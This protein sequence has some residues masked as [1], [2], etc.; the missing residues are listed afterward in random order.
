MNIIEKFKVIE[1]GGF[2][3]IA[4]MSNQT[5]KYCIEPL[6][7][8]NYNNWKFRM[9]MILAENEVKKL[10]ENEVDAT[11]SDEVKKDNKAK[12]LI[13][14]CV[15]DSQLESLRDCQTAYAMWNVLDGKYE[16]K[17][18]PGQLFLKKKLLSMRLK[19]NESLIKFIE[20]FEN[21]IRQLKSAKVDMKDDDMICTLLLSLPK[22]YE[23]IATVIENVPGVTYEEVKVK[24]LAESEKRDASYGKNSV[25]VTPTAFLA[26]GPCFKC[27]LTG[28]YK[29]DCRKN[30]N[31]GASHSGA[32]FQ[33]TQRQYQGRPREEMS[34]ELNKNS[35][36]NFSGRGGY[37][38][39]N[40]GRQQGK[41]YN[42]NSNF[43]QSNGVLNG[44]DE[45][46]SDLAQELDKGICFMGSVGTD[47]FV[48]DDKNLESNRLSK[49]S[50]YI[51]SGCTDHM[52]NDK[53]YFSNLIMLNKPIKIAVAKDRDFLNA[54][55]VGS[56][57]AYSN[58]NGSS[59]KCNIKNVL[60]VPDL[61]KNLLSVKKL[62]MF[63]LKVVFEEGNVKILDRN[64]ILI[65]LGKRQNLYEISFKVSIS[66]CLNVV[67]SSDDEY[68]KWHK[69]YG[70]IGFSGL[71][72]L[73]KSEMVTGIDKNLKIQEVEFCEPCVNGKMKRFPFGTRTRSNR[74]LEIIHTDVCGPITPN[75]YDGYRY[76]VTFIDDFSNF[77]VV[78]LIKEKGEV[79]EKFREFVSM[80]ESKFNSKV[81]KLRCDNGGEYVSHDFRKFGQDK[82]IIFDYTVPYTP[83]QNGKAERKN[84]SLVE[85][86][87]AILEESGVPKEFWGEV[88]RFVNYVMNRGTSTSLVGVTPAELWYGKKPDVS[89]LR[90]FGCIA[91]SHIPREFRSKFDSKTEKC[92]MMGYAE[93][94]YRLWSIKRRK[95]ILSRDVEFDEGKFW[96]KSLVEIESE[97]KNEYNELKEPE[98]VKVNEELGEINVESLDKEI[99][100]VDEGLDTDFGK[101]ITKLPAKFTDYELYM[102]FDACSYVENVPSSFS[103]LENRVDKSFWLKAIDRELQ[104][105]DENQTWNEVKKPEGEQILDT[106]WVFACKESEKND[107]DKYKARL[108]VRGFAQKDTFFEET[109][110]PVAK[111]STIRILLIVGNQY[112]FYF[113]QLDVKTAFLQSKLDENVFIYPPK[114]VKCQSNNVLKLE[115]SLYGLKQSSKCWNNEINNYL[116]SLGFKRSENDFCFYMLLSDTGQNVYLLL[117]V[118]D[119]I[120]AGPNLIFINEIKH[121]LMTKFK[122]KDK[123]KLENFLGIEIS[124]E[125]DQGILKIKQSRYTENLLRKFNMEN[126]NF[127]KI[128]IDPKLKFDLT[129]GKV[130]EKPFREL[131]GC[132]MYLMLGTRPDICFSIN[133]FSRYQDQASDETWSNIKRILRYLKGTK[134]VGLVYKRHKNIEPIL[135]CFVDADW[136]GDCYD[137][138][139]V[140]GF[141]FKIYDSSFLWV[142]RKQNCVS[143]STTEA[144]LVALCTAVSEV[145]YIKKLLSDFDL[146]ITNINMYE[147]NQGCIAII[148]NPSNNKRVKHMDLKYN[149]VCD[150]FKKGLI[151]ISYI[152][153]GN[154]QADIL[155]KGLPVIS[156]LKFFDLLGLRHCE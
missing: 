92:V 52:I 141:V 84:R 139:S 117:Y 76:F 137:R 116:L 83:Q 75:T 103:E 66:E 118:D 98:K 62:E 129:K 80:T 74:V 33:Q 110:S 151:N 24:L 26:K 127:S 51:D 130:T 50:F 142:T 156:F 131:V 20:D 125:R 138:K 81:S 86:S 90:V 77:T 31:R 14:Q 123:G 72:E 78:Y 96:F 94:G 11:K 145:L 133:Y 40:R 153:S 16:K 28:H 61:R 59:V 115:K 114:G 36:Q 147:D 104:S 34:R 95:M 25:M 15:D 143:L 148:K 150:N 126:C 18:L 93:T 144:E 68:L 32:S 30:F 87:R 23:T 89:N 3:K 57:I 10:V 2:E 101:R 134:G 5:G 154:N 58:V 46:V 136:A 29:K 99:D 120:L 17:G 97:S 49:L 73:I 82:G 55:A 6:N 105:I 7:G 8:N 4:S 112:S 121:K 113:H 69:R 106:K 9:E 149:F 19:E 79:F 45:T 88:I 91:Y 53:R 155:T 140:T 21:I 71:K 12:S 43:V 100:E 48:H 1:K 35:W 60:Y 135:T 119:I 70:H 63:G 108:V 109:Y 13:I 152:D 102:A 128:P 67:K 111:M 42:T 38:G 27:G 107:C 47:K 85:R 122:I 22:S 56:I 39:N 37:R 54:I 64:G 44:S 132:L 41:F 124:Y 65:G 146:Y